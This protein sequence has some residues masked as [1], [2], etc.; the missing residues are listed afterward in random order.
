M[1]RNEQEMSRWAAERIIETV[2]TRPSLVL[3]LATGSTPE[4]IYRELVEDHRINGTSYKH[5]VTF[6]L[7]EYVGLKPDHPNS[8]HTYMKTRLFDHLDFL[9]QR[10]HIPDGNAADLA[11]ECR[12]Y[13]KHISRFGGIDLQLLGIGR[14][15]HIGFN[16]PGTAFDTRTHV[17]RLTESTRKANARFF[18]RK[19]E[20]PT[21]AITMGIASILSSRQI[22]LLATG[23]AKAEALRRLIE[24]PVHPD[25][26]ASALKQHPDVTVLA[27]ASACRYLSKKGKISDV[28]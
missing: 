7:D 26:P 25:F 14:N 28:G 10:T 5:V 24:G 21:H 17:V 12:Q 23:R 27:D 11:E 9:P 2:R 3:G 16:E 8:Y 15:G 4:G 6:N 18:H 19:E 20:V 13:E 1:A 22:L